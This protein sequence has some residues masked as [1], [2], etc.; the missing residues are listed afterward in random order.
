MRPSTYFCSSHTSRDLPMPATPA[1][2]RSRGRP[3]RPVACSSSFVSRSSSSRPT[4]GGSGAAAAVRTTHLADDAQRL[5]CRDLFGFPF[6]GQ[7]FHGHAGDRLR[8]RAVRALAD[9]HRARGR[10][11]LQP[12]GGVDEVAG[13]QALVD[14]VERRRP[15]RRSARRR[16]PAGRAA[17]SR[18]SAS[19]RSTI[20]SAERTARSASSS[21]ATGVPHTA[22]TASPMNFSTVPPWRCT[23]SEAASK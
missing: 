5:P 2:C 15:P 13:H 1:M 18:P 6:E 21:C 12:G 10:R 11:G 9:E 22:I 4:N 7:R 8:H 14:R 17:A 16:A 23:A 20:S 19:T 3:S